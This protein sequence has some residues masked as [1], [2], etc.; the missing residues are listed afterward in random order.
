MYNP[1]NSQRRSYADAALQTLDRVLDYWWNFPKY[2]GDMAHKT[3][4]KGYLAIEYLA[5]Q[6]EGVGAGLLLGK[7]LANYSDNPHSFIKGAVIGYVVANGFR[8]HQMI[9]HRVRTTDK[10]LE[11]AQKSIEYLLEHGTNEQIEEAARL[12]QE[13]G[14]KKLT[15]RSKD[16]ASDSPEQ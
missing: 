3:G 2:L 15:E 9:Q 5:W 1:R 13:K 12:L 16:N 6:L 7:A 10:Q 11:K 8:F 14:M 4:K